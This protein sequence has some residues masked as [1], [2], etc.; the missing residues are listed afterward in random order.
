MQTNIPFHFEV[1]GHVDKKVQQI[2]P[3]RKC[4]EIRV[5]RTHLDHVWLYKGG[6]AWSQVSRSGL[7]CRISDLTCNMAIPREMAR[8][9]DMK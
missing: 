6:L 2:S 1:C 3:N 9:T 7:W 4:F 5:R 8:L